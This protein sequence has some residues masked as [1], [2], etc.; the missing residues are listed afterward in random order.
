MAKVKRVNANVTMI[1]IQVTFCAWPPNIFGNERS[2]VTLEEHIDE[3]GTFQDFLN[4]LVRSYPALKDTLI[5]PATEQLYDEIVAIVNGRFLDLIGG[6]QTH[7]KDGDRIE[8]FPCL[9][10]G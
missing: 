6:M 8:F 4:H 3:G 2:S 7:L 9:P 1:Q 5:D 10:G